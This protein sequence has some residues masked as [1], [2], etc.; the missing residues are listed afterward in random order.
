M[1]RSHSKSLLL[2]CVIIMYDTS[3]VKELFSQRYH[4]TVVPVLVSTGL[5][6]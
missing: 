5:K 4:T 3:R 1:S 2:L 6:L